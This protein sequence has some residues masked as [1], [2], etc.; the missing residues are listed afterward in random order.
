MLHAHP[1]HSMPIR[2][3]YPGPTIRGRARPGRR[4]GRSRSPRPLRP[5]PEPRPPQWLRWSGR[6]PPGGRDGHGSS[7]S[8]PF[9]PRMPGG[10]Y[11][12]APGA[13]RRPGSSPPGGDPG[14]EPPGA[15]GP[16]RR[17]PR[18]Q[19][20]GCTHAFFAGSGSSGPGPRRAAHRPRS[21]E[22]EPGPYARPGGSPAPAIHRTSG[23]APGDRPEVGAERPTG[24]GPGSR[25]IPGT[26]RRHRSGA[27]DS[28]AEVRIVRRG[29]E[30]E[31]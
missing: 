8:L 24:P 13:A 23:R 17:P 25:A 18:G 28:R 19:R 31:I 30:G 1:A 26:R 14:P 3:A 29:E 12:R 9:A 2:P 16:P 15:R 7:A 22:A 11:A 5:G 21:R 4:S 6:R 10:R 20:P 27:G